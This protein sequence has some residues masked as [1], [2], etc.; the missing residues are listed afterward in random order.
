MKQLL[1]ASVLASM[2]LSVAQAA[3]VPQPSESDA[4]V[5]YVTYKKDDV[6]VVNVRR[7]AV[8]RIVLGDDEKI[9]VSAA[10]FPADCKKAEFEWCIEAAVGAKQIFVKPKDG[11]THNNLELSTDKRDYSFE[12]K[13]LEDAT[14]GRGHKPS[15]DRVLVTEPMFR[16]IFRYPIEMP[17]SS[18]F[19]AINAANAQ[20]SERA[21][22]DERLGQ[23]KPAAK[24]W[25]YTQ[26]VLEGGDDIAPA[27]VF[28]DGRFTYFK[29]PANREIPT[30]YYI[31]PAGEEARIN[32][33]MEGDLAVVQRTGRRFV[34]RLGKAVVGIWNESFDGTGVAPKDGTTVEGV[35][36]TLR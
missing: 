16:V 9:A 29:F 4:R 8:T 30:I 1:M 31:D 12:F 32:F 21:L 17:P 14:N 34:L 11:A 15:S 3:E 23:A 19:M 35:V 7:G 24:N 33:H 13:V 2:A 22:L 20:V 26:Q 27:M 28:D 6:T 5:R 36:R 25:S 18:A 10:G